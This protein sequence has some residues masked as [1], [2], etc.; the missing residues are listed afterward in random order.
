MYIANQVFLPLLLPRHGHAEG[1][2]LTM[3]SRTHAMPLLTKQLKYFTESPG[4]Q[5]NDIRLEFVCFPS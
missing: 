5:S 1:T 4:G 3:L 2:L